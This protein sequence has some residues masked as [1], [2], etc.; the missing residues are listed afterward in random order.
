M[1]NIL[2]LPAELEAGIPCPPC[3]VL[4][5]LDCRFA[6]SDNFPYHLWY[7]HDAIFRDEQAALVNAIHDNHL[8]AALFAWEYSCATTKFYDAQ[9]AIDR[10]LINYNATHCLSLHGYQ[11]LAV[12]TTDAGL[13]SCFMSFRTESRVHCSV[14]QIV[15]IRLLNIITS[16][17]DPPPANSPILPL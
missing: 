12:A 3:I 7:R 16:A 8:P 13:L 15:A 9:G 2:T 11:A 6:D 17:V 14:L 10:F 4:S 5:I 1:L